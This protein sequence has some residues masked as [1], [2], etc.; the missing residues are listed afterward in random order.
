[1]GY[2]LRRVG[3]A[4]NGLVRGHPCDIRGTIRRAGLILEI[5]KVATESESRDSPAFTVAIA[6]RSRTPSG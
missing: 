2:Q 5:L 6:G 1:M 3:V 4:L